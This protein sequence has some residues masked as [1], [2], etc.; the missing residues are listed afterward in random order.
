[1]DDNAALFYGSPEDRKKNGVSPLLPPF[2][3]LAA[4][5]IAGIVAGNVLWLLTADVLAFGRED[6]AVEFTLTEADSLKDLSKNLKRQGLISYPWLF[7]L[8]ARVTNAPARLRPGTYTLN[9]RYDYH[10]LVK[11][12]SARKVSRSAGTLNQGE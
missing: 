1:M 10:A 2:V 5:F 8:Y 6:A 11:A 3:W 9:T 12:L 7:R 4:I